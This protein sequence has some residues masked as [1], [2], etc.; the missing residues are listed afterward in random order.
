MPELPEVQTIMDG[1][2]LHITDKQISRITE[3]RKGTLLSH[4]P[5]TVFGNV[6]SLERRGK[7]LIM[8]TSEAVKIIIHLGMT[9]KLIYMKEPDKKPSH[10][11]AEIV[12]SDGSSIFFDDV[13]TFGKIHIYR[14]TDQVSAFNNMGPEPLTNDLNESYLWEKLKDKKAPI[15]NVLMNQHIVAGLGNIYAMEILHRAHIDP[16]KES[17]SLS[18]GAIKEI[19]KQTKIV[20]KEAMIHN[21]TSVSDYRSIEDKEGEFQNFLRVYQK[22]RC[23]C[24]TVINRVKMAGRS[25]YFCPECQK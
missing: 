18:K 15:K 3:Y 9:G 23:R 11:R 8:N 10:C 13:R 4:C 2:Q 17:K 22:D 12:F 16:R 20:L 19:V 21:G 1:L 14:L 7:Y 5:V 24:G 25:T 6:S